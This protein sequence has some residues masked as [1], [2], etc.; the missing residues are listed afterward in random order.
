MSL[1]V[2]GMMKPACLSFASTSMVK[3]ERSGLIDLW[4]KAVKSSDERRIKMIL[5]NTMRPTMTDIRDFVQRKN[6][7]LHERV[8]IGWYLESFDPNEI[9]DVWENTAWHVAGSRAVAR[10]LLTTKADLNPLNAMGRT[11]LHEQVR[12]DNVEVVEEL[13]LAGADLQQGTPLIDAVK[14]N[15]VKMVKMLM[16]GDVDVKACDETGSTALHYAR[17]LEIA[18]LLLNEGAEI[19]A[20]D[21]DGKT[22]LLR[23]MSRYSGD[24]E[25]DKL[26]EHLLFRKANS[27]AMDIMKRTSLFYTVKDGFDFYQKAARTLLRYGADAGHKDFF[28]STV[29]FYAAQQRNLAAIDFF[30]KWKE[31]GMIAAVDHQ[32]TFPRK[33]RKMGLPS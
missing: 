22:P 10:L 25:E 19:E 24:E 30:L 29:L 20:K 2:L 7:N 21:S 8:I 5:E 33:F 15:N 17:N 28:G 6:P 32:L 3:R 11:P 16:V 31:M 14:N 1:R 27:N 12:Q 13:I 4:H 26:L 18:V 9:V 23:C